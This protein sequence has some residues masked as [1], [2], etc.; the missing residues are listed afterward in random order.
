[1]NYGLLDP[2]GNAIID[3]GLSSSLLPSVTEK[4]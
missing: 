1:M 4:Q 2:H 3:A